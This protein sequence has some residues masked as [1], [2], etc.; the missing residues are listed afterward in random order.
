[1]CGPITHEVA[2]YAALEP[3]SPPINASVGFS[4]DP[5]E[6]NS[7]HVTNNL[8]RANRRRTIELCA[9]TRINSTRK[10]QVKSAPLTPYPAI[11]YGEPLSFQYFARSVADRFRVIAKESVLCRQRI[12][13]IQ[14]TPQAFHPRVKRSPECPAALFIIPLPSNSTKGL[15]WH[16]TI[17]FTTCAA[18]N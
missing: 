15:P 5:Y 12:K 16:S 17:I 4:T 9:R 14:S 8:D 11:F 7:P 2:R 13:K 6:I 1:M 3:R 18:T 10:P